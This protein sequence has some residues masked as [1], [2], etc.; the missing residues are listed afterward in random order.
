[1]TN[2]TPDRGSPGTQSL[3]RAIQLLRELA[4]RGTAG[5]SLRDLA[6]H[7]GLDHATVHRMLKCLVQ[8]R[9]VHQRPSD[10]RYLIGPLAFELGLS[11][12][13]QSQLTEGTRNAVRRLV[14][15]IPQVWS[16]AYLRSGDDCVCIARAGTSSHATEATSIRVGHRAPLMSLAGGIA[17]LAA[18]PAE[19][20]REIAGR[21][22]ERMAHLGPRHLAH[23]EALIRSSA[24][25]GHVMSAG[26]V[27]QGIHAVAAS[28][29]PPGA[30][31]GSVVV[32]CGTAY[33]ADALRHIVPEL[34]AAVE[35]LA[36][37]PGGS[38]APLSH[39]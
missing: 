4:V 38:Q 10:R 34:R 24:R 36:A 1:M 6:Q 7:C 17:I 2:L 15:S 16:V 26:T 11:L 3:Q 12:P 9:L 21:N 31:V 22:R 28:F 29:G 13:Q 39:L 20:A 33:Q 25:S 30:P 18:L 23:L 27:W 37:S 35:V 8:E 14:R 5:W 19:Q 32:A